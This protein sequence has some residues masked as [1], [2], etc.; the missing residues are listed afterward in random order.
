MEASEKDFFT[1]RSVLST[2]IFSVEMKRST[3]VEGWF[4]PS[5]ACTKGEP[6]HENYFPTIPKQKKTNEIMAYHKKERGPF[7]VLTKA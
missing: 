2:M 7:F 4:S 6:S 5:G 3:S 1:F